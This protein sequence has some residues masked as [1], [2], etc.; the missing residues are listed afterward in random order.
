MK[1]TKKLMIFMLIASMVLLFAALS[2]TGC[3]N[4]TTS[5]GGSDNGDGT[6][7]H[8]WN[9]YTQTTLPTCT[10]AGIKTRTC[11][12]C[13]VT[14]TVTETGDTALDH[15]YQWV[16]TAT[17]T[18]DG[19]KAEVCSRNSAHTRNSST[20]Y[21]T[22]TA[23]LTF[24]AGTIGG[25]VPTNYAYVHSFTP[26]GGF[27]GNLYIPKYWLNTFTDEYYPVTEIDADAFKDKTTITNVTFP[28]TLKKIGANA[29]NGCTGIQELKI[30]NSVTEIGVGA[31]RYCSAL[32]NMTIPFVG[33]KA[34]GTGVTVFGHLFDTS[35]TDHQYY[36]PA[37]LE[38]VIITGGE[39]IANYAFYYCINIKSIV[40]PASVKSIGNTAF[41]KCT[42]LVGV[43][44]LAGSELETIGATAFMDCT[45][46]AR[47]VIPGNEIS[48][49]ISSF[50]NCS[51]LGA[52]YF[53]GEDSSAWNAI[54]I[55][56][57]S[58]FN[59]YFLNIVNGNTGKVYYYSE[60]RPG[61]N[62][63]HWAWGPSGTPMV[64]N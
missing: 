46:L 8:E 13:S 36:V 54:T 56:N 19:I 26:S 59:D 15:D 23:G 51:L 14:D 1:I 52:I 39:S 25:D 63:T 28:N 64:W 27:N 31:F 61:T 50:R 44:I 38:E 60:T 34:N 30:P 20:A 58:N 47:V 2:L 6:C 10:T 3:D 16:S 32:T 17:E 55:D 42:S 57:T 7:I 24:G 29:F 21:A 45:S 43:V 62:G 37:T 11:K 12:L 40:I 22:G 33:E 49:A 35:S 5:G 4:G 9:A 18:T 53:G 48:I 41:A